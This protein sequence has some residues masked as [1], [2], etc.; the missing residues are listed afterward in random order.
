MLCCK[1][2]RLSVCHF[3]QSLL[4]FYAGA[5]PSGAPMWFLSK[6]RLLALLENIRLTVPN[7]LAYYEVELINGHKRIYSTDRWLNDSKFDKKSYFEEE[8]TSSGASTIKL[9]RRE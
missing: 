2:E 1:L 4:S 7:N 9:G 3:R 5:N 6:G 8:A